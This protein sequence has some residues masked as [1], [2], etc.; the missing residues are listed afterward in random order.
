MIFQLYT[1]KSSMLPPYWKHVDID[2]SSIKTC[3][4]YAELRNAYAWIRKYKTILEDKNGTYYLPPCT[5]MDILAKF[6]IEENNE[7]NDPRIKFL[8]SDQVYEEIK[9]SKRIDFES[10][11]S[12]VGGF[13]GIF[14]GYSILQ[15]PDMLELLPSLNVN[16]KRKIR[17]GKLA[18]VQM[19]TRIMDF[20]I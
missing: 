7:W 5:E 4:S 1:F 12:G 3:N 9:N 18:R 10:F 17:E 15:I 14:L 20:Q 8:Y 16:L 2:Y 11:V 13:I 6:D 19:I